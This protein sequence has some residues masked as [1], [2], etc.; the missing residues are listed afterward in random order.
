MED[1]GKGVSQGERGGRGRKGPSGVYSLML[2][3]ISFRS[4][5]RLTNE[6]KEKR[7]A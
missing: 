2:F 3:N 4:D 1:G 6:G 5:D 7:T